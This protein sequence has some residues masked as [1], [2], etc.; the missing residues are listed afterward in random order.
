MTAADRSGWAAHAPELRRR[1]AERAEATDRG[2]STGRSA[3]GD[4]RATAARRE[5]D[6]R[7]LLRYLGARDLLGL[8]AELERTGITAAAGLI[9]LI[10]EEC[11]SSAFSYWAHRMVI[12]YLRAVPPGSPLAALRAGLLTGAEAGSTAMA[13]ALQEIAGLRPVSVVATPDGSGYRLDGPIRWASNLVPGAVMVLPAR[14]GETA[15]RLVVVLRT[16]A[17]GV[18][19]APRPALLALDATVSSS[20]RLHGARVAQD[21]VLTEDLRLFVGRARPVLLLLQTAFCLGLAGR[22]LAESASAATGPAAL[23][24]PELRDLETRRADLAGRAGR[25][26]RDPSAADPVEVTRIRY[27]AARLTLAATRLESTLRGGLGYATASHTNRRLRE[28]AFLP[29]QSPSEIQLRW[30]LSRAGSPAP[31]VR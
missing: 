24:L 12:E 10:A 1:L 21:Q 14:I 15:R 19:V 17:A 5:A 11:L 25:A 3:A 23:L 31:A 20:V 16:D 6:L 26:Q 27:E 18:T 13:A 28:A 30:E 4:R 22:A 7:R 2:E 29:V 9:E 8:D